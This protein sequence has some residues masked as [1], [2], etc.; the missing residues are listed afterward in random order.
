LF[1]NYSYKD[2]RN[3]QGQAEQALKA[4]NLNGTA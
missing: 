4:L 1:T 3:L 2:H